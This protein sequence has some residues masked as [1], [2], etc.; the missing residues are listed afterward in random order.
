MGGG[1]REWGVG[2]RA[3]TGTESV[4][5]GGQVACKAVMDSFLHAP[6]AQDSVDRLQWSKK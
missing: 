6:L 1:T 3:L 4:Y 5:T 2:V